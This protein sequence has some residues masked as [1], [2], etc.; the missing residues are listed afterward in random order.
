MTRF[1]VSLAGL[2]R[3][4]TR[5][6]DESD[7]IESSRIELSRVEIVLRQVESLHTRTRTYSLALSNFL[8]DSIAA[9]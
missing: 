8:V 5:P 6:D 1:K 3:D 7:R 2:S 9:P 4:Q